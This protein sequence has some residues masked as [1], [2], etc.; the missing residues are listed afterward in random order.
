M[1]GR[2]QYKIVF[3]PISRKFAGLTLSVETANFE[4]AVRPPL[5]LLLLAAV[6]CCFQQL[7]LSFLS[8]AIIINVVELRVRNIIPNFYINQILK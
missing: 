5:L 8:F 2:D 6:C 7:L 3:F 1:E 4:I